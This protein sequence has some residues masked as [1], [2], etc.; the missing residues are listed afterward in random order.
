MGLHEESND[1]KVPFFLSELRKRAFAACCSADKAL[2]TFFGRPPRIP[3]RYCSCSLPL[4]LSD[5]EITGSEEVRNA[6]IAKLD[7]QGWNTSNRLQRSTWAR[8][9]VIVGAIREEALELSLGAASFNLEGQAR[10]LLEKAESTWNNLPA[11]TQYDE[12][13]WLESSGI[14]PDKCFTLLYYYLHITYTKFL[15]H[16]LLARHCGAS[17]AALFEISQQLLS[18]VLVITRYRD[19]VISPLFADFAWV[20]IVGCS[21]IR[22]IILTAI[23]C[24]CSMVFHLLHF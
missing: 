3:T 2:S 17:P 14:R 1:P 6:A 21:P 15:L 5:D 8:L 10:H 19:R 12:S 11:F 16:R 24:R 23:R 18:N 7:S 20:S 9:K 4:D 13:C 22:L